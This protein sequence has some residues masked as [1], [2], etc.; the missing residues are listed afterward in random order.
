MRGQ[1]AAYSKAKFFGAAIPETEQGLLRDMMGAGAGG[2][3]QAPTVEAQL[4]G[5]GHFRVSMLWRMRFR[6]PAGEG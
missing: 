5:D 1:V 4:M 6:N 3:A 2:S